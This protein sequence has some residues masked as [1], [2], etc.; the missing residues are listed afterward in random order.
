[1]AIIIRCI[2][3]GAI[4]IRKDCLTNKSQCVC[5]ITRT[6]KWVFSGFHKSKII[7]LQLASFE[8]VVE[9]FVFVQNKVSVIV[10][11]LDCELKLEKVLAEK[12]V[13]KRFRKS[14]ECY[15]TLF[16]IQL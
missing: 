9:S 10:S 13:S 12:I 5:K 1:M 14:V 6:M 8:E 4:S 11:D 7:E 2:I 3:Y 16:G 15:P